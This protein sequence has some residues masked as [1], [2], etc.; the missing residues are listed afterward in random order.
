MLGPTYWHNALIVFTKTA[1]GYKPAASFQLIGEAKL[2]SVK[3]GLIV[4]YQKELAKNDPLY[5]PSIKKR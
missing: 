4:V 2:S 3:A 5:C 1:G